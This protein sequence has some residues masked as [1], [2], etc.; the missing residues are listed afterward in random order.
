[1]FPN[2]WQAYVF[3][4]FPEAFPGALG[5]SVIRKAMLK[6][7]WNLN[8]I[9]L[10]KFPA[11]SDRIDDIPYGGGDGMILSPV[12]FEKAFNTLPEK[13]KSMRKI[14]FSPRGKQLQQ[15]DL[16]NISRE[17]GVIM[18]CGRYEGVDQRILD[19][20][21]MEEISLGDF[22]LLGGD[23]AAMAIIEGCVRLIPDVVGEASSLRNDSF[24]NNLLEYDQYTKPRVWNELEVP[25]VLLSG[26]HE[27]VA[28][29]RQDQS[30]K[31]TRERRLDLWNKYVANSMTKGI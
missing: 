23:V 10:K 29:M 19:K 1:M 18:L 24:Q 4:V 28:Q 3:T 6:G 14:Y 15:Q 21:E 16:L 9:D 13:A 22:V 8:L 11:N 25:S 31:I 12:T 30:K 7:L 5:V 17:S 2:T 26:N 20:Y 27:A